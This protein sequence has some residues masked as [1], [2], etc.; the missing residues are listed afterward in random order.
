MLSQV[1]SKEKE[2]V[3]EDAIQVISSQVG[4]REEIHVSDHSIQLEA[5]QTK[6]TTFF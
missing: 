4:E 5:S 3:H 1:E 2:V 6:V